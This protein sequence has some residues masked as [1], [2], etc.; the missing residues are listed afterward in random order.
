ML[1][2]VAKHAADP[3]PVGREVRAIT[4]AP[5]ATDDR[6]VGICRA[7]GR[8]RTTWLSNIARL[9]CGFWPLPASG[10]A[11]GKITTGDISLRV[12]FLLSVFPSSRGDDTNA[13]WLTASLSF[14]VLG[15]CPAD[16]GDEP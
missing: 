12:G 15:A 2:S 3:S 7:E 10:R 13:G 4:N 9:R 1:A 14:I 8:K 16:G 5:K 6:F 11:S